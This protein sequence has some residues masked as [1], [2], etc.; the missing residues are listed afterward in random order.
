MEHTRTSGQI[1]LHIEYH[2]SINYA[3]LLNGNRT[4]TDIY[5]KNISGNR[6]DDIS[7]RIGGFYFPSIDVEIGIIEPDEIRMVPVE[8]VMPD[9]TRLLQLNEAIFTEFQV[10]VLSDNIELS[11]FRFPITIQA[12]NHWIGNEMKYRDLASFVMPNHAYVAHIIEKA[13][14]ILQKNFSHASFNGYNMA[15]NRAVIEQVRAIWSSL[16]SENLKYLTINPNYI[17]AGQRVMTP[18]MIA[19][20]KHGNC[21]D[22]SLLLCSCLERIGL[23]PCLVSVPGHIM[24]G[25][26]VFPDYPIEESVTIVD[27]DIR[28]CTA[29]ENPLLL[30]MESTAICHGINLDD[31]VTSAESTLGHNRIVFSVDII[32]TR[33]EGIRSI[34]VNADSLALNTEDEI[35]GCLYDTKESSRRDGWERKLLDLTLRNVMLNLKTGKTIV[36]IWERDVTSVVEHMKLNRLSELVGQAEKDN[37]ELLKNL[38]RAARTSLEEN[39]ANTLF[40]SLGTLR[41]FDIDDSRPHIAPLLFIPVSIVRKKAMTYEVRL[42]DDD[43]MVN[44]T[45][46]E[47]LRQMFGVTFPELDQLP[48][49]E[50]GFPDW[51][52]IF[53][54]FYDHIKEINK[55]QPADRQWELPIQSYIG[56]F[57]FTK[58]LMWHDVHCHPEVIDSHP[59]L[60]GLLDNHYN[61]S[62]GAYESCDARSIECESL[63][64]LMMPVDYDSSQL[65]A[66]AECHFG[67]SFVLHGPPGTGKSQTITN[68]IADALYSGKR[69]LFVAEKKAALDVVRARLNAIGLEPYCLELHSNKADKR[70]FFSQVQK[71][72]ILNL[73]NKSNTTCKSEKYKHAIQTL[74]AAQ[75]HLSA[76]TDAIHTKKLND[77]SLY[78]C[79]NQLLSTGYGSIKI[80]YDD[81]RYLSP[82][83][84]TELCDEFR[85]LDLI[86]EILGYHPCQ[87]DLVGL[88]PCENTAANQA[89]VT[90][91]LSEMPDAVV[92]ARKKA[93]SLLNRWLK[94]R[95]PIEILHKSEVWQYLSRVAVIDAGI[96]QDIDVF[97]KT[98]HKWNN[99]IGELRR[100]YH[101]SEKA[102]KISGYQFS[103]ALEFYLKGISGSETANVIHSSYYRAHA[104]HII[105]NDSNLRGFSG[106]LHEDM[107]NRYCWSA[108]NFQ[109]QRQI[110]LIRKMEEYITNTRLS[111]GEETQL[112]VLSRRLQTN[113]RRV[114]LRKVIADSGD[115]LGKLFPCML[116]SPLSVAQYLSMKPDLFDIVIFDEASQMETPDAVG[117][118]ARGRSLVVVGD[119]LQLPPT[120]FFMTQDSSGEDV[121]ENE[122]SDSILEDCIAI[123]MPSRYLSRHYRS[124]H[125][126][127]IA[128]SNS[129]FYDNRLLTFPSHN[130]AQRKVSL[131]D[132]KGTYDYGKTRTNKIEAE[133]VVKHIVELLEKSSEAPSIGIVAFS[134]A[135]SNLIEDIFNSKI[136]R[137]KALQKKLDEAEEPLFI[138]NL[139]NVQ[140][141]ERDIIIFSIGYGPDKNGNVSL[142]F[143][144]LNK[145]GGK[146]RLNVAVSRARE[147]MIVFSSLLPHH[148]PV[149][150][151]SAK[152]V[153][154]LRKF[155]AYA[156]DGVSPQIKSINSDRETIIEDIAEKM[157]DKGL[158]VATKVGRSAFKID[159]AIIDKDNP[160]NY[161]LGLILDGRDYNALP[162]VRDREI[163]V[164]SVLRS[165]GWRLYRLWTID[166]FENPESVIQRVL[167]QLTT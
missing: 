119:P 59:V 72:G 106:R 39:G 64:D 115:I 41:W 90:E 36:P 37:I 7:V 149:D 49:D 25:V 131:I 69:V 151:V 50:E 148:I 10:T 55:R 146:R 73:G 150:G 80:G 126:S 3:M 57:S 94:K 34:P 23:S 139:E 83:R 165:L 33:K 38:Y 60:R 28:N 145:S 58:F 47:M 32:N 53:D 84:L 118:I 101:F 100:W 44:V 71:S 45:L 2:Q 52:K 89:A 92:K 123:G 27:S 8:N 29:N 65:E 134:K 79:I 157:R 4:I 96:C 86:S 15:D 18:E 137:N 76:I 68:I 167:A 120:R 21:L 91:A 152:G 163:T 125:E 127:L 87:S 51:R 103:K 133:A 42:R 113:G 82:E 67:K 130:D 66:V 97:E 132:P 20:Y 70:S 141:D 16:L 107:V 142:N 155:L 102:S 156:I 153:S 140:G 162:T 121:E 63:H 138:K 56:I 31:A 35:K 154:A 62:S 158:Q 160:D 111:I 40:V 46:I 88:Y 77:L 147:E 43:A 164:P 9:L 108:D 1:A 99:A 110:E 13:T 12:W 54:I 116:M 11:S 61:Q 5:I 81:V 19:R 98:I 22:L 104:C 112:A 159:I 122:D 74:E 129:H 30:L 114:A 6:L 95:T 17:D 75:R 124:R 128:F 136:Q 93:A 26:W 105:D 166:W 78:D 109:K 117:T 85:S 161:T 24:A 143:G 144:P 48:Q 14:S 135:Q